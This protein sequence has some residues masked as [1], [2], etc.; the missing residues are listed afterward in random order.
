M[1]SSMVDMCH[2]SDS[3]ISTWR[4]ETA[5]IS[6]YLLHV[7]YAETFSIGNEHVLMGQTYFLCSSILRYRIACYIGSL[8]YPTSIGNQFLWARLLY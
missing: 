8:F 2:I 3:S 6:V 1:F 7:Y 5:Y 4:E